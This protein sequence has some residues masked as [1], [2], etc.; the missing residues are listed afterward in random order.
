MSSIIIHISS[1]SK[2]KWSSRFI[3]VQLLIAQN[4]R[5]VWTLPVQ[6]I[7]ILIILMS[8][9]QPHERHCI[10]EAKRN[11]KANDHALAGG[12]SS[13]TIFYSFDLALFAA[14]LRKDVSSATSFSSNFEG[15]Q[16]ETC[17]FALPYFFK[18]ER[19]LGRPTASA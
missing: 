3:A 11:S 15:S 13:M 10:G 1:L 7:M 16:C 19:M 9:T 8:A 17:G 18:A 6:N 14:Y 5:L 12:P 2:M 4:R